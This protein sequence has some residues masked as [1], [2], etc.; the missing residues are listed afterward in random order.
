MNPTII[1]EAPMEYVTLTLPSPEENLACDEALLEQCD[2]GDGPELLRI[3]EA[4]QPFV[5]LGYANRA[6][7]EVHLEACRARRMPV[8]RRCTGGGTVVQGPGC[9]NFSLIARIPSSGPFAS[10]TGT[11]HAILTRH[12]H[13]LQP[14]VDAPITRE[15][16]T[17]LALGGRKCSGNAQRRKRHAFLFHGTLLYGFDVAAVAQWLPLPSKQP[18]YRQGRPHHAFLTNLPLSA[19]TL[20]AALRN[21]WQA[22]AHSSEVPASRIQELVHTR[23]AN[24]AWTFRT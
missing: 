2:A 13:A 1:V 24:A 15:P 11:A 22:R 19:S 20:T 4:P 12:Q 6:E 16:P 3:W 5:V 17:D 14:L 7:S 21:A 9:L 8:V 23:Y 18:A 10:L